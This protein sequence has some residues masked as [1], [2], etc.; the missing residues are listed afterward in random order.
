MISFEW[1]SALTLCSIL[2]RCHKVSCQI[3]ILRLDISSIGCS[4]Y[5]LLKAVD[6]VSSQV[7]LA[8]VVS[9]FLVLTACASIIQVGKEIA[10]LLG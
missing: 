4:I 1:P 8:L 3:T 9:C 6:P 5:P 2:I 10:Y 7:L